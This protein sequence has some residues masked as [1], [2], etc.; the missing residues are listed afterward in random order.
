LIAAF[1]M[2]AIGHFEEHA[3]KYPWLPVHKGLYVF[4]CAAIAAFV[5]YFGVYCLSIGLSVSETGI[6]VAL[7]PLC[8]CVATPFWTAL[9][10]RGYRKQVLVGC[11]AV[12]TLLRCATPLVAHSFV[13]L[14]AFVTLCEIINAPIMAII[15]SSTFA[16]LHS[17]EGTSGGISRYGS[18]RAYGA[19]GW[20]LAAPIAGAVI[21]ATGKI[22]SAYYLF[23]VGMVPS[24]ILACVLPLERRVAGGAAVSAA[25]TALFKADVAL[26]FS[27]AFVSGFVGGGVVGMFLFPFLRSLG[28][29]NVLLGLSLT[30]TCASE[31]PMFFIAGAV[32]RM[33][34]YF[35]VMILCFSAFVLR[36]LCY[37]LLTNP[38][39][40][41]PVE[42]L[43]GFSYALNWAASTK[44][45]FELMPAELSTSGQGLLSAVQW[46]L[47]TAVGS[48]VAGA[49]VQRW[50][51]QVV[52]YCAGALSVAGG[53]SVA[54]QWVLFTR[55]Q[56]LEHSLTMTAQRA[57]APTSGEG[58]E[59]VDGTLSSGDSKVLVDLGGDAG[60][61]ACRHS[62]RGAAGP[63]TLAAPPE[64]PSRAKGP[65]SIDQPEAPADL[66]HNGDRDDDHV[67]KRV[68]SNSN[69]AEADQPEGESESS[70]LVRH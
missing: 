61:L 44:F 25:F 62:E 66:D 10:D 3:R 35:P 50:G 38:W 60:S 43:H 63:H 46:G 28:A 22:E 39:W 27:A 12:S 53:M 70:P 69:P 42:T 20:G 31:I 21:D 2:N 36:V 64:A 9:C 26:F 8:S 58:V 59:L 56:K 19:L 23:G 30:V 11:I 7:S 45:V 17:T 41:L 54:L 6:L 65:A 15:D 1:G 24:L 40:T 48:A 18:V 33:C 68:S 52:F 14:A 16:L 51:Y 13:P 5:P 29:P 34:G 57:G 67:R 37:S 47:G 49:I 55:R 4:Y 32:L